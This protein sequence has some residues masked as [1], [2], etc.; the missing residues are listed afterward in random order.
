MP[1]LPEYKPRDLTEAEFDEIDRLVMGCAYE[2][3]NELGR[4]ND[5][6]NYERDLADRLASKGLEV[7]R[8]M[9]IK[10]VHGKFNKVYWIDL[11]VNDALYELKT[12]SVLTSDHDTQILHY[13]MLLDILHGKLVNFREPRVRGRL[14]ANAVVGERFSFEFQ[15]DRWFP[16]SDACAQ[17]SSVTEN[18]F[19][20]LGAYLD[21]RLYEEALVFS[22]GGAKKVIQRVPMR[23]VGTSLGTS[24]FA[25]HGSGLCFSFSAFKNHDSQRSHF[26]R[27]LQLSPFSHMQWINMVNNV[28]HFETLSDVQK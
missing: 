3:Q 5:E 4:L 24:T 26:R 13:T 27:R 8:Q 10:V 21:F 15:K 22:F 23:R 20:E 25:S 28:I 19:H 2:S 7:R 1:I 18:L 17:L 14:K 11:I 6:Q 16:V 9:P 12:V